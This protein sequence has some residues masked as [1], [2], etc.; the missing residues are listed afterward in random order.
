MPIQNHLLARK[1]K[2]KTKEASK[3]F[4]SKALWRLLDTHLDN[5]PFQVVTQKVGFYN[6]L[7]RE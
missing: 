4:Q 2:K 7:L 1:G 5:E 3:K 6:K